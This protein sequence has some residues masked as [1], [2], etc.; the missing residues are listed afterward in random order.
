M[1]TSE[2][3]TVLAMLAEQA[4]NT[5][6]DLSVE[7]QRAGFDAAADM[8]PL[9][10]EPHN[11]GETSLGGVL[12][13]KFTPENAPAGKAV[14]YF[15]GGGYVFGSSLSH[16]HLIARLAVDSEVTHWGVDYRLAPENPFPAALEDTHAAYMALLESGLSGSDIVLGG[17]SAGGGLALALMLKLRDEGTPLPAGAIMMSPWVD[18]SVSSESY[19]TRKDLDPMVTFEQLAGLASLYS[20]PEESKKAPVSPLF[21]DMTDL[22]P[23]YIQVGDNEL[24]LDDS[25]NLQAKAKAAGV[26]AELEIYPDLFHVFQYY[27]PMLKQGREA[28][29]EVAQKINSMLA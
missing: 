28:L 13:R 26:T 12:V 25:R 16:R 29:T 27:W 21:G 6:A 5:P 3:Q 17:D 20:R 15:H 11:I 7:D 14:L 8:M 9:P 18:M 10:E 24:L 4:A 19:Q 2:L 1:S 22:P 23:L